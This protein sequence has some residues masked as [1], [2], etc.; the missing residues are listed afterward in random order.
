MTAEHQEQKAPT[1]A[2]AMRAMQARCSVMAIAPDFLRAALEVEAAAQQ[3]ATRSGPIRSS[4]GTAVIPVVG[5]IQQ[6]ADIFSY[7]GLTT[8]IEDLQRAFRGVL[9]DDS[10]TS[11]VF[12]FD[13]P[14]GEVFGVD[15]FAA[16]IF[17]ARGRKPMTAIARG[18]TASA[19]YYL[20]S[21]ADELVGSPTSL[22]GSIGVVQVHADFSRMYDAAGI[23]VTI[24]RTPEHKAEG[25][26]YEPLSADTQAHMQAQ[27]DSYYGMFV[28]AVA[29]GRNV[30]AAK[31]RGEFGQGRY[32]TARDAVRL[33][34]ADRIATFE[35]VLQRHGGTA[36][37]RGA[38]ADADHDREQLARV[39]DFAFV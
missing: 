5:P 26:P 24:L 12:D 30:S 13:T 27:L 29:R 33:G 38:R 37:A 39:N 9:G 28:D 6:R 7:F 17:A 32:F 21:Q 34:M 11:I 22:I 36:G 18:M 25:N 35:T 15:E 1:L 3:P 23:D 8:S 4:G 10:V 16:E 2:Q 14:G 31:V 19:G 20:A